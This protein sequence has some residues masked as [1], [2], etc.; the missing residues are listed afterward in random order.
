MVLHILDTEVG[1]GQ[2]EVEAICPVHQD[3]VVEASLLLKV[4]QTHLMTL[5]ALYGNVLTTA[6]TNILSNY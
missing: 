5:E 4:L 6:H 1:G 2:F 3:G